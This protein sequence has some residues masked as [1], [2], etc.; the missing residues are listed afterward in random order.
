MR[1]LYSCF[2]LIWVLLSV[3][4]ST[5]AAIRRNY[6]TQHIRL[7]IQPDDSSQ[8]IEGLATLIIVPMDTIEQCEFHA[9]E[10]LI[11]SVNIAGAPEAAFRISEELLHIDFGRYFLPRDTVS[12]SIRYSAYPDNGFYFVHPDTDTP[13]R[14]FQIFSHSEP[15]Y[16][17]FW[18]PCYDAPDD[19]L[20]SEVIATIPASF[21]LLSNGRLL[22]TV[23]HQDHNTRTFHWYQTKPHACYLISIAAGPYTVVTDSSTHVPIQ[24]YLFRDKVEAGR[25]TFAKTPIML[26]MFEQLFGYPYPWEKYAQVMVENY[27]ALGMEHTSATHIIASAIYE[28]GTLIDTNCDKLIAHELAHQW[29][30][31]LVTCRDWAHLW[32][33]EGF[34]TY[35]EV[36]FLEQTAGKDAADYEIYQQ[37]MYYRDTEDYQFRQPIVYNNYG[38]AE[39]MF[40]H[41]SYQKA[42]MV[43]HML[44]FVLGDTTFFRMLHTY[45]E[46]FAYQSISTGEFTALVDSLAGESLNWFWQQW[47]YHG[48]HPDFVVSYNYIADSSLITLSVNQVQDSSLTPEHCFRMPVDI[49]IYTASRQWV[50]RFWIRK[51]RERF[52]IPCS[53]PPQM[54]RFD[55]SNAILKSIHFL[56]TQDEAIYQLKYDPTVYGQLA[57]I[58]QLEMNTIDT[59]ATI[60]ALQCALEP[61]RFWAVRRRSADALGQWG[62]PASRMSLMQGLADHHPKVRGTCIRALSEYTDSSLCPV[63]KRIAST[64]SSHWVITEALYAL[65]SFPDSLSFSFL[66]RFVLME[67]DKDMVRTAAFEA[68]RIIKD[69]RS[70]PFAIQFATNTGTSF[71]Q[72]YAALRMLE[73]IGIND[74]MVEDTL[75]GLLHDEDQSI[76]NKAIQVLGRFSSAR[77]VQALK[78]LKQEPLSDAARRRLEYALQRIHRRRS[79]LP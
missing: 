75:I 20:T 9:R 71:R 12:I 77:V 21:T 23:I 27:P 79:Q 8:A 1:Y 47:L 68:L 73:E 78:Q 37:Q 29:F 64:D 70:I 38:D 69:K 31:N 56:K 44:R 34:A 40:N 41:I 63:F 36:L 43:L 19:K 32:L 61:D 49:A 72:R 66:K 35:A 22:H 65:L 14:H 52:R 51:R 67:S 2:V 11:Q 58:E 16:A 10:L 4:T 60:R 42:S 48:G 30:G 50:Q 26:S 53:E 57:A 24:Y 33:N 45:L 15:E 7:E 25:A 39:E 13:K 17:R 5:V 54:I 3:V 46:R 59:V 28:P 55:Y 62:H 6:D 18:F 74:P 76:Q